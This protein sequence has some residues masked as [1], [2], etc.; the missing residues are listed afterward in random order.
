MDDLAVDG[1]IVDVQ[2]TV[3]IGLVQFDDHPFALAEQRRVSGT[4]R[5]CQASMIGLVAFAPGFEQSRGFAMGP[6]V[7]G[8]VEG[9]L[10][11]S[12]ECLDF[13]GE[14][15]HILTALQVAGD[16]GA[17]VCANLGREI[18]ALIALQLLI[19]ALGQC[20]PA[21]LGRRQ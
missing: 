2:V 18:G 16:A 21:L 8:E 13:L 9:G 5:D 4:R 7:H 20:R 1:V 14:P 19:N 10:L 3:E 15:C 6:D 12:V 17:A 11:H